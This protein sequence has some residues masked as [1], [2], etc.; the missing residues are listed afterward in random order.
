M[1][2]GW[3][4]P[5]GV[6][7]SIT[8]YLTVTLFRLDKDIISIEDSIERRKSRLQATIVPRR[9]TTDST[10]RS[11][12]S[13][14]TAPG[15]L[16]VL[17]THADEGPVRRRDRVRFGVGRAGHRQDLL[18]VDHE[19]HAVADDRAALGDLFQFLL[20]GDGRKRELET[21]AALRRLD[22]IAL[23][24]PEE[25]LV[26]GEQDDLLPSG[27]NQSP[28]AGDDVGQPLDDVRDIRGGRRG[29]DTERLED[30]P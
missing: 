10:K 12:A 16:P 15:A 1:R 4:S 3:I 18:A 9:I 21:H 8:R 14:R 5:A 20:D 25:R 7:Y 27:G 11:P 17:K 2:C 30:R 29:R 23:E 24:L 19:E 22:Q 26:R 28:R 13:H 6:Q